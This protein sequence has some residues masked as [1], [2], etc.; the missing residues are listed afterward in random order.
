[1]TKARTGNLLNR[2][3]HHLPGLAWGMALLTVLAPGFADSLWAQAQSYD[4]I[5]SFQCEPSDGD[6]PYGDLVADSAG[7]LYGVTRYGGPNHSRFGSY[8]YGTVYKISPNGMET[9]LHSFAGPPTDG[10]NPEAGLVRDS[11]G[12]F[13]GTTLY[14][15]ANNQGTVFEISAGGTETILHNFE[16]S[17]SDAYFVTG[18]LLLDPAGNLYGTAGGGGE[19]GNG[20]VFKL[21][22]AGKLTLLYSFAGPPDDGSG[23]ATGLNRD[24]ANNL[25]STTEF[26]GAASGGTIFELTKAGVEKALYSFLGSPDGQYPAA[27]LLRDTVGN[28]YGTTI[29]GGVKSAC[30]LQ[31]LKGCGT[32]FKLVPNGTE[33]LLYAFTGG[34]DGAVPYSDLVMDPKG[35]LYGTASQGGS[36]QSGV[37]FQI[38][39]AGK[40]K[41]LHTFTYPPDGEAPYGGLLFTSGALYGTTSGGGNSNGCGTVFKVTP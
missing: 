10:A 29:A 2:A 15:G 5:Y 30:G 40:E 17:T 27:N 24:S 23:P 9:V 18:N 34:N 14:G 39:S 28:L 1:M 33:T 3:K 36:D 16:G 25:Y 7:N 20:A 26:G 35:N 38:T 37:V 11:S 12:N 41:L 6:Q 32:V 31:D 4:V 13:Y 19:F 22:N 21:S 8:G